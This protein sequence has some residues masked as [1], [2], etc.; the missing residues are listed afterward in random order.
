MQKVNH[1]FSEK[2]S[3]SSLQHN[4]FEYPSII[5]LN[6]DI[7]KRL[8]LKYLDSRECNS[9]GKSEGWHVIEREKITHLA[10]N[11]HCNSCGKVNGFLSPTQ[12]TRLQIVSTRLN[13]GAA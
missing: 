4:V 13:G 8:D 6:N 11:I 12:W 5:Q 2:Q 10:A 3:V 7:V 9:C 1:L